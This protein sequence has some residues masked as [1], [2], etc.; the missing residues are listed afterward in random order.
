MKVPTDDAPLDY[1][2]NWC[3]KQVVKMNEQCNKPSQPWYKSFGVWLAIVLALLV[4]VIIYIF[5]LSTLG[6]TTS[7]LSSW[8]R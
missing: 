6:Y 1:K 2:V 3:I 4:L 8:M 7:Y 5:Y